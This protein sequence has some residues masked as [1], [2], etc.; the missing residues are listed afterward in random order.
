MLKNVDKEINDLIE[1]EK[2]R[3]EGSI[4]LIASENFVSRAVLEAMGTVLNNKYADGYPGARDYGGCEYIDKV[5]ELAI[6]RAKTLFKCNYANVQPYSGTSANMAV[7]FALLNPGDKILSMD[8]SHGGHITHGDDTSFSKIYTHLHY[9]VR[10]DNYEIDYDEVRN[11]ALS[12][13]PK[14]IIAGGSSYALL[15]DYKRFKEIASEVGAYLVVDMAH[16]AGLICAGLIPSPFPYA[17]IVTSTTHKT[18]RGPRGGLILTNDSS[19]A[20]KIDQGVF[21]GNQ[22]GPLMHIIAGKA[23]AFKEAMQD[24]FIEYQKQILKNTLNLFDELKKRS[25]KFAPDKTENHLMVM[26][27]YDSIGISGKQAEEILG[28]IGIHTNKMPIPYETNPYSGL[29]IGLP[30]VTSRGFKD[31]EIEEI[32]RIIDQAL[33]NYTNEEKLY[34]LKSE[35]N[36]LARKFPLQ[37]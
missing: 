25:Y 37:K 26:N 7:F 8:V 31:H 4:E 21:P 5:E 9:H 18:L 24:S 17:D 32:A 14:I 30:A 23:V 16:I 28:K 29:R 33:R 22:G 35:V 34:N 6:N 10:K 36:S 11:I 1:R 13:K 20:K 19:L 2:S 27:V 15:I 3:E 12:E